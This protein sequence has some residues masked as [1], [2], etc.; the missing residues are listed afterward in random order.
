MILS[1]TIQAQYRIVH[2]AR[3][4]SESDVRQRDVR[5]D[6]AKNDSPLS[7]NMTTEITSL[8]VVFRE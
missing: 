3:V 6:A 2:N 1:V 8:L 7:H 4:T 5:A